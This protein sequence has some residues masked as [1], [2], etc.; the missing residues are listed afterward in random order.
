MDSI[1]QELIKISGITD[2]NNL[3]KED[4]AKLLKL[5][6]EHKL[7]ETHVKA[8]VEIAPDFIK[9][10]IEALKAVAEVAKGA[11]ETQKEVISTVVNSI[12]GVT[13][14][15]EKLAER[16]NSDEA[17]IELAKLTIQAGGLYLEAIKISERINKDNNNTWIKIGGLATAILGVAIPVTLK[18][19]SKVK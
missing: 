9:A 17:I 11:K 3:S 10:Q 1:Q 4:S 15:L 13:S 8:L 6:G 12:Q 7:S 5:I 14:I 16:T 18:V 2:F 19:L